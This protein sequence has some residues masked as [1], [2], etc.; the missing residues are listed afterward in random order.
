MKNYVF[1]KTAA[2]TTVNSKF[3]DD[4]E[5]VQ[6]CEQPWHDYQNAPAT[7][8][9][10]VVSNDSIVIRMVTDEKELKCCEQKVNGMVCRDSC[11]EFFFCPDK[12][13]K[14]YLNFEVNALG[15]MHVGLGEGRHGRIH[16]IS[17]TACFNCQS[18]IS[19]GFWYLR[20]E[21]PFSFIEKHFEK[22]STDIKANFYKCGDETGHTHYSVWNVV[23]TSEPDYHRPEFF[24]NI[25]LEL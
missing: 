1:K 24:G 15:V 6:V 5:A 16:P 8:A 23:E 20:Y 22:L 14:R 10:G 3:W 12:D 7:Y 9:Q 13:D 4:V 25:R 11:M 18:L 21:I 19:N 2:D 17:D